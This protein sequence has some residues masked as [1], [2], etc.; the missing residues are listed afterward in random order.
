MTQDGNQSQNSAAEEKVKFSF[1]NKWTIALT[2]L[3]LILLSL[4]FINF[5]DGLS[6][7][8]EAWGTFGD[9]L[10]GVLNPILG[11][12]SFIALLYTV[13]LQSEELKNSNEQLTRSAS[14]QKEMEKTQRLQQ[15][16]GLFTYMANEL[17]KIHGQLVNE[18]YKQS[19]GQFLTTSY[20]RTYTHSNVRESLRSNYLL[21]RFFMYLYQILKLIDDQSDSSM[22]FRDRKRYSNIIRSSI[23]NDILQLIFLNCLTFDDQDNDFLKYKR[24]LEKY[25]FFEHMTF[26][27]KRSD[28]Y[29]YYFIC[30][31]DNYEMNAYDNN[32][33]LRKIP[34]NLI[35][36]IKDQRIGY[37]L[38]EKLGNDHFRAELELDNPTIAIV[39]NL[40]SDLAT[41]NLNLLTDVKAS[42]DYF[43]TSIVFNNL[44]FIYELPNEKLTIVFNNE[45]YVFSLIYFNTEANI[46]IEFEYT[47]SNQSN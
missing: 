3:I 7:K 35:R 29:N 41:F 12:A 25:S 8:N 6:S 45:F 18:P 47:D 5:H 21:V 46:T 26:N 11:F 34:I 33:Y 31:I 23:E 37:E 40:A 42:Y 43:K 1:W 20:S 38:R 22:D 19:A 17:S 39:D 13:R 14:A 4:Y 24:L 27:D 9:Y 30:L 16:E 15:F 10:G 28:R 32:Y 36:H 2:A 44:E